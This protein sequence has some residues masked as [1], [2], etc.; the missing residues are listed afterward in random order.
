MVFA[1][2][3]RSTINVDGAA[4]PG[5]WSIQWSYTLA[6]PTQTN[7]SRD[8][9]AARVGRD[10]AARKRIGNFGTGRL[11]R[12]KIA[13]LVDG[14]ERLQLAVPSATALPHRATAVEAKSTVL[15]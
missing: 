12:R 15:P 9:S 7:V 14:M 4:S 1:F 13:S 10:M 6:L 2:L 5:F 11:A 8:G 3:S